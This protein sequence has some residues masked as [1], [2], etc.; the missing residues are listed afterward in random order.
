MG[1][2]LTA[3][4]SALTAGAVD[5][6]PSYKLID[7]PEYYS[8]DLGVA[9]FNVL[10]YGIKNDGSADCTFAVQKLLDEAAGVGTQ[11]NTRSDYRN[12]TGGIVYFPAGVYLFKSQ[13]KIPRG[14]TIRGDWKRPVPGQRIEGTIFK[15]DTGGRGTTLKSYAFID[16]YPTSLVTNLAFWYPNQD[17]ANIKKYPATIVYGV[18]GYW[19]ND[20]CNVR[21]CTFVNSYIGVQFSPDGTGGCPNVF[22]VY[23]TPLGEGIEMDLIADVGRFDGLHFS[24][25]YWE[26]SGLEGS[27]SP[28]QID[29]WLYNNAIGVVMRR[30]D[31]SYTCNADI[32]GY[33]IGFHAEASPS[34]VNPNQ[35]GRPNGHNYGLNLKN[36][37]TGVMISSASG[38]GIM[39]TNI[40]TPGCERGIEL[41]PGPVGPVQFYGCDIDGTSAAI[42][43]ADGASTPL[44]FQDCNISG[45]TNV[46]AGHFQAVNTTFAEDVS[47]SEKARAIFTDNKFTS[48]AS[49]RNN[50]MFECAVGENKGFAY[51]QLP[52]YDPSLMEIRVTRPKRPALYVVE[53]ITPFTILDDPMQQPDCAPAIQAVMDKAKAEGGGIVYIPKGHY[54]C[55]ASLTIPEGVELK[56]ASD[57]PTV[58]KG[59]GSI[60]EVTVGEG[61]ESGTPFITM[62]PS[63]GLRGLT[64]NYP[65]QDNPTAVKKYPYTV[66]GN[67]DCYIVNLAIRCAYRGVD[68]FTNKCDNHYVDYLAGHAFMN[69]V[70]V[71]GNSANGVISNIQCNTIA[72]ACGDES[73]FGCWPNSLKM[74][75]N[76]GLNYDLKAYGQNK[77]DLEF[78][79][80]GDC[81]DE[82]L[83]NNFLFG[84]N[85]GMLFQSDGAGGAYNCM[86]LGNAVDGAVNTFVVNS[87][88]SDLKL[89]NSQIV[90][91]PHKA[92][93]DNPCSIKY[94]YLPACFIATGKDLDKTV[95]FYSSNNWGSG[96]YMTDICGGNVNIAMTNM[97]ASG[98][99]H[100]CKVANGANLNIFNARFNNIKKLVSE[101]NNDEH[102]TSILSSVLDMS[103]ADESSF[104]R[105]ENNLPPNW[106]FMLQEEGLASR[107]GWKATAFN[108]ETGT[109]IAKNAIDGNV[110]SRWSTEGTQQAGQW[111]MVD[112]GKTLTFN[113]VI[114]DTSSSSGDGPGGYKVEVLSDNNWHTVAEGKNGS[115]VSFITFDE[116]SATAV[117]V[118]QTISGLKSG[119]WSIHE[120]YVG[121][122]EF[123][124]I[125]EVEIGHAA[126]LHYGDGAIRID[127]CSENEGRLD[128]YD[129]SGK[130]VRSEIIDSPSVDVSSL[131]RGMYIA[132]VCLKNDKY[133]LKFIKR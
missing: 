2:G 122:L 87:V 67:A 78:F 131:E 123:S 30:N 130:Y 106:N 132:V 86:S 111:F 62:A 59:N 95:T 55:N 114:L 3:M 125:D 7:T 33:N 17:P 93:S 31:W 65:S 110:V 118:T 112:F 35:A 32:E 58:P 46:E 121:T 27:P 72:Y 36:C 88:A 80:V 60:L 61:N 77:E 12:L 129:I 40:Q 94:D 85:T 109:R 107:T 124:G 51:P 4:L 90:A 89:V 39:F 117:R 20:Y 113:T 6:T 64:I 45:H 50:S 126:R 11:S 68:L 25:K 16:M 108:D 5:Y 48:G 92:T 96:E 63:S 24:A 8:E 57:I 44:M 38:S 79:I 37:K 84:C 13:I 104:R 9:T 19:G 76:F 69:V 99:V 14:V 128:I 70:R 74:S 43:M 21:H 66:R 52:T 127:G 82:F 97:N 91:I 10:D 103:N 1:L 101:P 81:R 42:E 26:G 83:Y 119:Y 34:T 22:D 49:L 116:V 15:L 18:P 115:A 102:R 105:W 54:R 98:S 100:T 53:G 28:G 71:G 29:D 41:R 75:N 120:F 133:Y 56:G 73:K 23:G 47:I